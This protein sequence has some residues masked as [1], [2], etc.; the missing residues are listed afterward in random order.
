MKLL[1]KP[2]VFDATPFVKLVLIL[3]NVKLVSLKASEISPI[4]ATVI[5]MPTTLY[6]Q[7]I[8]FASSATPNVFLAKIHPLP[9]LYVHP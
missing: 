6:K 5:A 4:R 3:Q 7:P 8:S 2:S 9:V 1:I